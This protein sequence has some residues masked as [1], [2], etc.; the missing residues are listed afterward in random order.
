[1]KLNTLCRWSPIAAG[2]LAVSASAAACGP[3]AQSMRTPPAPLVG[4][5][6][7][8]AFLP[9]R[10]CHG[11]YAVEHLEPYLS[12]AKLTRSLPGTR[13]VALDRERRCITITV[14]SV[15]GGRLA[16]LILRGMAVPRGAVLLV[17]APAEG[18]G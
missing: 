18:R 5:L 1:M 13:A 17:L 10:Q 15:G 8:P 4:H 7:D 11:R 3:A 2:L 9:E 12:P 16:E 14:E 6:P